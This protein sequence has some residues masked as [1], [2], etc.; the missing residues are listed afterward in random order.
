MEDA[1]IHI[2]AGRIWLPHQANWLYTVEEQ[3]AQ[4]PLGKYRDVCDSISQYINRK[5]GKIR[6]RRNFK[7]YIR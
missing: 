5:Y 4:F 7:G 2:E 1:I 3:I 6:K